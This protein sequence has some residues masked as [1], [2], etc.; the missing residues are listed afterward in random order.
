MLNFVPPGLSQLIHLGFSFKY[1]VRFSLLLNATLFIIFFLFTAIWFS[2]FCFN[3]KYSFKAS[4]TSGISIFFGGYFGTGSFLLAAFI[5]GFFL[6]IMI[7][8]G[9]EED[10]TLLLLL[11]AFVSDERVPNIS[12]A[13]SLT[14]CDSII[15]FIPSDNEEEIEFKFKLDSWAIIYNIL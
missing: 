3:L 2:Y 1:S 5:T 9:V 10:D 4:F 11:F 6:V 14:F 7:G 12:F 13:N 15:P 8:D